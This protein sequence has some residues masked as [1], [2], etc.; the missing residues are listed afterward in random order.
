MTN[1]AEQAFAELEKFLT[2][3]IDYNGTQERMKKGEY[4]FI[5]LPL[6]EFCKQMEVV[7]G[8]YPPYTTN[9]H[10]WDEEEN[11]YKPVEY[12]KPLFVDV[13]CGI[14]TKLVLAK[15]FYK[16][17]LAG[18]ECYPDYVKV[19]RELVPYAKIIEGNA[20]DQDYSAYDVIYFYC[21]ACNKDIQTKLEARIIETAK[22]GAYV[23]ANMKMSGEKAW[24]SHPMKT[25]WQGTGLGSIYQKVG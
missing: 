12:K 16:F 20:L 18:I 22:P 14:G 4:P 2:P 25:V 21:P 13:G 10:K 17:D 23:L 11:C 24:S 1:Y 6:W 9:K 8:F 19:A 3:V 7:S 15:Q 5:A